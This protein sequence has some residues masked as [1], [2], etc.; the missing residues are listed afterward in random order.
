[1]KRIQPRPERRE[2]YAGWESG[3]VLRVHP[4]VIAPLDS[5]L[6]S[7]SIWRHGYGATLNSMGLFS[8]DVNRVRRSSIPYQPVGQVLIRECRHDSVGG[9]IGSL[10]T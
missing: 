9:E 7:Q 10:Q 6:P 2:E 3:L 1:M 4:G 8:E 5:A